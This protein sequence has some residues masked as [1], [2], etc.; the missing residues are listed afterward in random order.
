[1]LHILCIKREQQGAFFNIFATGIRPSNIKL[2][3]LYRTSATL[4]ENVF[5]KTMI[6]KSKEIV[7]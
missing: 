4:V 2:M 6:S 3:L 7:F 1:M 5:A